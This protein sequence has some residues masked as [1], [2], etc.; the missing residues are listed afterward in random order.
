[1]ICDRNPESV[2]TVSRVFA[3]GHDSAPRHPA[4]SADEV[5]IDSFSRG[6]FADAPPF[7]ALNRLIPVLRNVFGPPQQSEFTKKAGCE[8][9]AK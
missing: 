5:K 4:A 8:Q 6:E 7:L 2:R 3:A 9:C 1:M